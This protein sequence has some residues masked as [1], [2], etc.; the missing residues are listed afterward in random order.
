[1]FTEISQNNDPFV[2]HFVV[3]ERNGRPRTKECARTLNYWIIEL[4][5]GRRPVDCC[6][7]STNA[8]NTTEN[9]NFKCCLFQ[10][11]FDDMRCRQCVI[12]SKTAVHTTNEL[13]RNL[14]SSFFP[15]LVLFLLSQSEMIVAVHLNWKVP[16]NDLVRSM[17]SLD[18]LLSLS[19]RCAVLDFAYFSRLEALIMRRD[20]WF[21]VET[22]RNSCSTCSDLR[23]CVSEIFRWSSLICSW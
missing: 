23:N 6:L 22:Q 18:T 14:H 20:G 15:Y 3:R 17:K 5:I 10:V 7:Q 9:I 2:G 16:A 8:M 13:Q 1:M 21:E 4:E 12:A 11:V 19:W